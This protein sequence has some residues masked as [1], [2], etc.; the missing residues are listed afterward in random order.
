M[1]IQDGHIVLL[2]LRVMSNATTIEVIYSES[3][4][5]VIIPVPPIDEQKKI[6]EA[7]TAGN[8]IVNKAIVEVRNSVSLLKERRSSL[9]TAAVTGQI[10]VEE[11]RP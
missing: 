6:L 3:L 10:P 9:I 1:L 2:Q 5:S 11:M 7:I 8:N 4:N